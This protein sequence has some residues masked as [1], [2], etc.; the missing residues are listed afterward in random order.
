[1]KL[2][3][4]VI[5]A[6]LLSCN[7]NGKSRLDSRKEHEV[8]SMS[9]EIFDSLD[10]LQNV[11]SNQNIKFEAIDIDSLKSEWHLVLMDSIENAILFAQDTDS[12]F[13][14][15][16]A[17][18][19]EYLQFKKDSLAKRIVSDSKSLLNNFIYEKDDFQEVAFFYHKR[20]GKRWPRRKTITATAIDNGQY[21]L[22]SNYF[23][24]DWLFHTSVSMIIGDEKY[25]SPIVP[26]YH[27]DNRTEVVSGGVWEVV[28][29]RND[30]FLKKIAESQNEEIKL[31]FN[32]DQYYSDQN[33]NKGDLNALK[34]V[35]SLIL[36]LKENKNLVDSL[37][38][39]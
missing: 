14:I 22:A 31:R 39:K 35:Y 24:E 4:L 5:F 11:F 13:K 37:V 30:Q 26:R 21:L 33:L 7:S 25:N 19:F 18:Q 8:T 32:G 38:S 28:V 36:L 3:Y 15:I 6:T 10:S 1:M 9:M 34:D 12:L 2:L 20:W 16:N 27:K 23:N 17:D 29:Y